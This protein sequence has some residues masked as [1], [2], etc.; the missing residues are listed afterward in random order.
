MK[1]SKTEIK[2]LMSFESNGADRFI[3]K[4]YGKNNLYSVIIT[5]DAKNINNKKAYESMSFNYAMKFFHKAIKVYSDR[6]TK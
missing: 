5:D 2:E 4:I 3:V 6:L 1:N